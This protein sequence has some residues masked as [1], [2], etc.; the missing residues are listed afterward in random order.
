MVFITCVILFI[1]DGHEAYLEHAV[2]L[3]EPELKPIP[4]QPNCP[5]SMQVYQDHRLV[6]YSGLFQI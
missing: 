2:E 3:L 5:E 1:T 6:R 4:P